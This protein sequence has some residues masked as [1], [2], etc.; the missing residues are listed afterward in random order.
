[1]KSLSIY[2]AESLSTKDL[3]I[4]K[5]F[6]IGDKIQHIDNDSTLQ[7]CTVETKRMSYY[8]LQKLSK[9][10]LGSEMSFPDA[11]L[12]ASIWYGVKSESGKLHGIISSEY[13]KI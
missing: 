9:Y 8:A 7:T 11:I 13:T 4:A 1:M 5:D 3:L 12:K 6:N 10:Q 2:I